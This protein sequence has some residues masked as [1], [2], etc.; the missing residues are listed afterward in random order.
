MATMVI[1]VKFDLVI[2]INRIVAVVIPCWA[3]FLAQ[4][5]HF[6][7]LL[8]LLDYAFIVVAVEIVSKSKTEWILLKE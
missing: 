2:T 5:C 3:G 7:F 4:F 8:Q 6:C 1:N